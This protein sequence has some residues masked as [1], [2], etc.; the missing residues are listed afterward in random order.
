[1]RYDS[2]LAGV[3]YKPPDFLSNLGVEIADCFVKEINFLLSQ[4]NLRD[5]NLLLSSLA[6]L[7][8][9]MS[10]LPESK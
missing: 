4:E 9:G 8:V 2:V 7:G 5:R 10:Q 6:E 3:E 1:M